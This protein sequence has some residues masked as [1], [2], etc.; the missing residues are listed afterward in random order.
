MGDQ[1]FKW[2]AL[3]GPVLSLLPFA[4]AAL[5]FGDRMQHPLRSA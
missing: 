5:G 1:I 2:V 4:F 3:L